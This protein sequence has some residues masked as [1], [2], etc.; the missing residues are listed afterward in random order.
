VGAD[1]QREVAS[2]STVGD[3]AAAGRGQRDL[4]R[5]AV[6][7][8]VGPA[9]TDGSRLFRFRFG[10]AG[11]RAPMSYQQ[12]KCKFEVYQGRDGSWYWHLKDTNG[13]KIADSGQGY[14]SK[15]RAVEGIQNVCSCCQN[16]EIVYV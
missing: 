7:E 8:P 1:E 9:A 16:G 5:G 10:T 6:V 11:K 13:L 12:R 3:K 2:G 15:E 14:S 4:D